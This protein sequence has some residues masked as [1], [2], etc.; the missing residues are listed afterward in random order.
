MKSIAFGAAQ[1]ACP[2]ITATRADPPVTRDFAARIHPAV[3]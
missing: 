1:A 3:P 2:P